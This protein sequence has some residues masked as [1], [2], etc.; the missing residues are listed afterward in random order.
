MP[1][2][3]TPGQLVEWR[4]GGKWI[5]SGTLLADPD[6]DGWARVKDPDGDW[7][8]RT[9]ELREPGELA[10]EDEALADLIERAKG[11]PIGD[12][13][14]AA[15]ARERRAPWCDT[16]KRPSLF[17]EFGGRMHS[18]AEHPWGVPP[19]LDDSGHEVTHYEW[20]QV[21]LH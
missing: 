19:R 21:P 8:I 5:R 12:D 1:T 3:F 18:T 16:C 20:Y 9:D 7:C 13:E 6:A 11:Y 17:S 15:R 4:S 2:T 10:A 14:H